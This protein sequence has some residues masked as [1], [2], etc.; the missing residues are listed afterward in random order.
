[1]EDAK[2]REKLHGG[3]E[4]NFFLSVGRSGD[5][6]VCIKVLT[7]QAAESSLDSCGNEGEPERL[8]GAWSQ[9][10]TDC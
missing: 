6:H 5:F 4:K 3:R 7:M 8:G 1:L 2:E 10:R 9:Q